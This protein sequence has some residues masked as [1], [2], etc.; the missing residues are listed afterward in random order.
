MN[1]SR[2]SLLDALWSTNHK[3]LHHILYNCFFYKYIGV[4]SGEWEGTEH[5]HFVAIHLSQNCRS[6]HSTPNN[7][8]IRKLFFQQ[9][10]A[11]A[12]K[13]HG[14]H[15]VSEKLFEDGTKCSS[16]HKATGTLILKLIIMVKVSGPYVLSNGKY[17]HWY[18]N[19]DYSISKVYIF[20]IVWY[21]YWQFII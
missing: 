1:V 4:I 17:I 12:P 11:P 3:H 2:Q 19:K 13:R 6:L 7:W 10:D 15:I 14:F 8:W 9:N 18:T 20:G 21:T 16:D 5:G